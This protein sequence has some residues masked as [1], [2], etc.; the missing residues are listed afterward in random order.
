MPKFKLETFKWNAA[1]RFI[2]SV[3]PTPNFVYKWDDVHHDLD[4]DHTVWMTEFITKDGIPGHSLYISGGPG[5]GKSHVVRT[6]IR[7]AKKHY[8]DDGVIVLATSN[9]AA[10]NIGSMT[11][12][13]FFATYD[14][15]MK[16]NK[17]REKKLH[18][19]ARVGIVFVDEI[20]MLHAIFWG[21]LCTLKRAHPHLRFVMIG[22]FDQLDPV[23]DIAEGLLND[24]SLQAA[25]AQAKAAAPLP[26]AAARREVETQSPLRTL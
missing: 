2:D 14:V 24:M 22:D 12:H 8:S 6:G 13:K 10:R 25:A 26:A 23:C 7:A 21:K 18:E 11:I 16:R 20:S 15:S 9:V 5:C 17:A 19:M 3:Q 1:Q 4:Y